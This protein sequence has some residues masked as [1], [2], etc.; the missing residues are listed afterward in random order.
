MAALR[1]QQL[2]GRTL[3]IAP[4]AL[5][6]DNN[7][8]SWPN[9]FRDFRV[10][11][12]RFQSG[13]KLDELIRQGIENYDNVFID[14]SHR[15]RTE[16]NQTYEKL[17]RICRG[18]RVILVSATPLNN[19]PHD[20]LSQVKL[21]QNGKASTIPNLRNL[22]AFFSRL[23]KRLKGRDRQRD[24]EEYFT[25]VRENAREIREKVLKYLMFRRTRT[26]ISRKACS[27]GVNSGETK[28]GRI[29]SQTTSRKYLA[30]PEAP[31]VAPG[32][33]ANA[34]PSKTISLPRNIKND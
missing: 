26:E 23:V 27:V 28:S 21:F 12:A 18:K 8:G 33:I 4:P 6:D 20:I 17:A 22:E 11:Q 5:L 1:A 16:T 9:V 19:H 2:P 30:D 13:G 7:P 14:E 32:D 15:F 29:P 3:V 31:L 25:A 10:P 24:R 34:K